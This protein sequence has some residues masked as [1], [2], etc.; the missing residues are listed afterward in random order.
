VPLTNWFANKIPMVLQAGRHKEKGALCGASV[1]WVQ[2]LSGDGGWTLH[3]SLERR[4]GD[5]SLS[6]RVRRMD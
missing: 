3:D 5:T 4:K 6:L 2:G 1:E